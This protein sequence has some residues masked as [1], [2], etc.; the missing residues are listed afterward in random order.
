ML[1][2]S[3]QPLS[4]H[5]WTHSAQQ[6]DHRVRLLASSPHLPLPTQTDIRRGP[7]PAPFDQVGT[8]RQQQR[9]QSVDGRGV[10]VIP[11]HILRNKETTESAFSS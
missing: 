5:S 1:S 9:W 2:S 8:R 3:L 10:V 7:E 4:P 11:E 6:G